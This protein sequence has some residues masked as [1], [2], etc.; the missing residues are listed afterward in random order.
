[1]PVFRFRNAHFVGSAQ[2]HRLCDSSP[3]CSPGW[4]LTRGFLCALQELVPGLRRWSRWDDI[5]S[6]VQE[7]CGS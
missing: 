6:L 5:S 7:E 2:A 4:Y 1:M 3:P